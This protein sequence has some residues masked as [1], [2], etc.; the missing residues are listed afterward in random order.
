MIKKYK[1]KDGITLVALIFT[2][3]ILLILAG[4]GIQEIIHTGL[5]KKV[6][7]AKQLQNESEMKENLTLALQNLQ[8]EKEGNATLN[9][10]TQEW[11]EKEIKEYSPILKEDS[12]LKGKLIEMIKNNVTGKFLIDENLNIV[13][14]KYN[15][16]NL[17]FEYEAKSRNGNNIEILIKI[18]DS[19]NGINQIKYPDGKNKIISSNKKDYIGIDYTVELGKEYKFLITTGNGNKIEKLIKI[20]DYNYKIN[21]IENDLLL[22]YDAKNNIGVGHSTDTQ[23][24]KNLANDSNNGILNGNPTWNNDSLYF[25]GTDD[26][27]DCGKIGLENNHSFTYE[28]VISYSETQK[29]KVLMGLHNN[30]GGNALGIDDH[31]ENYLKFCLNNYDTQRINSTIT[32]NDGD[33]HQI[34]ATYNSEESKLYLYIDGELNNSGVVTN[35]LTY[36]DLNLNIGRW[37]GG[38]SQYYKGNIYN[39]LVYNKYLN[40]EE[41]LNNYK[42]DKQ[43]YVFE[44]KDDGNLLLYYDAKNNNGVGHSTDTQEWKNLANDSNSGILNGNP[45]WNDDSLHFDGV[46]DYIDCGKIGLE[47]NHSFT[48]ECTISYKDLPDPKVVI[49]G[50]HND[51]IG[52]SALGIDHSPMNYLKFHLNRYDTNK[53]NSS[54]TLNDDKKH[55]IIATYK[56]NRLILYIDG[57][58]DRNV[59]VPQGLTYPDL[60]FNIGRW[61][62]GQSQY[63]KGNIYSVKVY[64]KYLT[65]DE[66]LED[67]QYEKNRYNVE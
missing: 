40:N 25:D 33:I 53:I 63:Y 32:L 31:S 15:S 64:N 18:K 26:Y 11:V 41:I 30:M 59:V 20:D 51:N 42:V 27:I 36:P 56:G 12:S 52:G 14:V 49:M 28:C 39:V 4:L 44:K 67:Y 19:I 22:Y 55:N 17:E 58:L 29:T 45:T 21:Y 61:V 34:I 57:K 60:N 37:I 47:N 65:K 6:K 9:D 46:N 35:S 38:Q 1:R 3:I 2:I 23:E 5:F 50:L 43:K 7:Q 62:G 66:A 8:V 54:K 48:Y 16:D 13:Q 10:V 24:W